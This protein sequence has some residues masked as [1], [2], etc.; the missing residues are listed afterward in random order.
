MPNYKGHLV[1]GL[2]AYGLLFFGLFAACKPSLLVAGEWL[3][4]TLAGALFPDVDIKSKGQKYFY[5]VI[6]LF[7][8]I[9]VTQ[10]RFEMLACCSFV[11]ISP[12]L[13]NHRGIF[14]NPWFL[15]A[16]PITMWILLSIAMPHLSRQFF[17]DGIFFIA[18]A[19]SHIWLDF[20]TRQMMHKIFMKKK[21]WR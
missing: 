14:H 12:M 1:G 17:Y 20:G 10:Q 6:L 13:V 2:I 5:F 15:I 4:F 21:S 18:G 7:L 8:I 19:L 9:L 3:V 16:V 11:M